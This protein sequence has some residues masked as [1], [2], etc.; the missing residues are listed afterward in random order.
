MYE[1]NYD[2]NPDLFRIKNNLPI[3]IGK[4]RDRRAGLV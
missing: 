3:M 4:T 2:M 1:E